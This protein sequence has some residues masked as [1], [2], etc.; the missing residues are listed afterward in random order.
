MADAADSSTLSWR[1]CIAAAAGRLK[2]R[3]QQQISLIGAS[4]R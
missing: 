2:G 4:M 3:A 1:I